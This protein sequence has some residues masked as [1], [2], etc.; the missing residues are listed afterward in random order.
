MKNRILKNF[1]KPVFPD[2]QALIRF[3]GASIARV[4]THGMVAFVPQLCTD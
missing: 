3:H 2:C 1:K 4:F